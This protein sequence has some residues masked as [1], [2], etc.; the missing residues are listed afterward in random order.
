MATSEWTHYH[1]KKWKSVTCLR[2]E[3]VFTFNFHN[4][5]D[6]GHTSFH[7]RKMTWQFWN[8]RSDTKLEYGAKKGTKCECAKEGDI[9]SCSKAFA[10]QYKGSWNYRLV[11]D[12]S[13]HNFIWELMESCCMEK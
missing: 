11:S 6:K 8:W 10:K 7:P 4:N 2:S 3:E 13:C 5:G 12:R 1:E 9:K